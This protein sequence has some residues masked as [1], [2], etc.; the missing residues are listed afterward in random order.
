MLPDDE[1][2]LLLSRADTPQ[3]ALKEIV[4]LAVRRGGPDNATAVAVF[5][6]SV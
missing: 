5:V 6:D 1:I 4:G 2:G 3:A